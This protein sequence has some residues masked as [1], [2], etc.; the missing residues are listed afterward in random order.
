VVLDLV[1]GGSFAPN[2]PYPLILITPYLGEGDRFVIGGMDYWR[3]S[4]KHDN[5][6]PKLQ[7]LLTNF[8][9][10]GTSSAI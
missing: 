10:S 4:G 6:T 3:V 5:L 8:E 7:S 1:L 9:I 2:T